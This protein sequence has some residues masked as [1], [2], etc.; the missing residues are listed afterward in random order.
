MVGVYRQG[1]DLTPI[2]S[3]LAVMDDLAKQ[4]TNEKEA[5]EEAP[6]AADSTAAALDVA[7]ASSAANLAD[8]IDELLAA[9]SSP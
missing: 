4:P 2:V 6:A 8:E 5:P 1:L 7:E 3:C 9:P